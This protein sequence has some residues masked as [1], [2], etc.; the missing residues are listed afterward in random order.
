[1]VLRTLQF[2][3]RRSVAF[4]AWFV[5]LCVAHAVGACGQC[6]KLQSEWHE[7]LVHELVHVGAGTMPDSGADDHARVILGPGTIARMAEALG[8]A[9]P[10]RAA[11]LQRRMGGLAEDPVVGL[12]V[13]YALQHVSMERLEG[14]PMLRMLFAIEGNVLVQRTLSDETGDV[15]GTLQVLAPLALNSDR[16]SVQLTLS[17]AEGELTDF[18]VRL[19]LVDR[20][21]SEFAEG[22]LREELLS[23]LAQLT[24]AQPIWALEPLAVGRLAVRFTATRLTP[25]LSGQALEIGLVSNLRPGGH[26]WVDAGAEPAVSEE[27]TW[28]IHPG[29]PEA[30]VRYAAAN[31]VIE[32]SFHAETPSLHQEVTVDYLTMSEGGF[33]YSITRWCFSHAPCSAS[34]ES[35]S[36]QLAQTRGGVLVTAT[37]SGQ[38]ASIEGRAF[39]DSMQQVMEQVLQTPA[40]RLAGERPLALRLDILATSA[41]GIRYVLEE[42][43]GTA[44][45]T[46]P[47]SLP[48]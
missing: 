24:A 35:G 33:E 8:D 9:T 32:R 22:M 7:R 40:M 1:M 14:R 45:P 13:S 15:Y 23:Q 16:G 21:E 27:V 10:L 29:L 20:A 37:G 46:E 31:G 5:A 11:R 6:L 36:G 25:L 18:A 28:L 34:S 43:A 38:S 39:V 4:A 42:D 2:L 48:E 41:T 47:V 3:R 26:A 17:M 12:Q 44:G 30:A 19:D